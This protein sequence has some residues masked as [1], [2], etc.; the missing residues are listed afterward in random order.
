MLLPVRSFVYLWDDLD[1]WWDRYD[2]AQIGPVLTPSQWEQFEHA[3]AGTL[4][5][6]DTARAARD[7]QA[8]KTA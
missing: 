4:A 5:F 8:R 3:I 7:A 6:A 2:P 1:G